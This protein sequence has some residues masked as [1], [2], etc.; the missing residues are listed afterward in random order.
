MKEYN[1][2]F[3]YSVRVTAENEDDAEDMAWSA[4]GEANPA[5]G[6]EFVCTVDEMEEEA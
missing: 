2:T 3:Y 4:F 1:V 5:S 6:D